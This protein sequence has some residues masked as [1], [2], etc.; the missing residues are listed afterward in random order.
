M[1]QRAQAATK[2]VQVIFEY[3][4]LNDALKFS[5][6]VNPTDKSLIQELCYGVCRWQHRLAF[7]LSHLMQKPLKNKD[8]DI[9]CLLLIGIYQ[10]AY[11]RVA[12]HAAVNETVNA[13]QALKKP[14][15]KNLINGVLRNFQRQQ[16]SL[17]LQAVQNEEAN[18]SHPVWLIDKIKQAW[19]QHWSAVLT[20]NNVKAPLYLR[21]NLLKTTRE[22]YLQQL[23]KQ[24]IKAQA[25]A[26]TPCGIE[27]TEAVNVDKLPGFFEGFATVQDT[28][29]Q[30]AAY[31]LSPQAD[32][33]ILDA[34]A[35]PG[36]KTTHL[37]EIQ[38]KLKQLVAIDLG[39]DRI[40]K[41]KESC[42][43]LAVNAQ[44]IN[45]DANKIDTWWDKQLFDRILLDAPCSATGV[46]RRHPDIKIH[47]SKND[48]PQLAQQQLRLLTSL[49]AVLKP[50]GTLL[51][52]T[53]SILPEENSEV[54]TRFLK[55][56]ADA[57]EFT[58]D[59]EWGIAQEVGRQILPDSGMDGFYYARLQKRLAGLMPEKNN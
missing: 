36:G 42:I 7:Y 30:L 4:H 31:L 22:N 53:C 28:A 9:Y 32:E 50:G 5:E 55:Q 45:C 6:P 44:I 21:V 39:E 23:E 15:A 33:S 10:L 27:L 29:A 11:L 34:C 35:A 2:L 56:Q 17:L 18:Y 20:A 16:E 13:A 14:W 58:I 52:A 54:I 25:S 57:G 43:R 37:V 46:I 3:R 8:A 59:E 47:R 1:N 19:P 24:D 40:I 48:I 49:W 12:S 51:Y 38:P 26:I 41:L